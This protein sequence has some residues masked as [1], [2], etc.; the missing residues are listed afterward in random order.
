MALLIFL[1]AAV[2]MEMSIR[3]AL[4]EVVLRKM[5]VQVNASVQNM[6]EMS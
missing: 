4:G 6:K 3:L 2:V 1:V 5:Y